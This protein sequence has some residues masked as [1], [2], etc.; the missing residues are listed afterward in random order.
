MD[1]ETAE[2]YTRVRDAYLGIATREPERFKVVDADA[3]LETVHAEVVERV[4]AV[5][6]G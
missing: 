3:A 5:L 2:F 1:F 4:S 6:S